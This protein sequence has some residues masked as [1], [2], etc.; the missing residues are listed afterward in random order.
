VSGLMEILE[1]LNSTPEGVHVG[2]IP[3]VLLPFALLSTI[4]SVVATFIANLF[5]VKLRAEG[6]KKLLEILLKPR[7]LISAFILNG[8]LYGGMQA[9][10]YLRNGP[11]PEFYQNLK[12]KNILQGVQADQSD[13]SLHWK[14][15]IVDDGF[16]ADAIVVDNELFAGSKKGHLYV[17]N[18]KTGL[19]THKVYIGKFIAPR[20]TFFKG[21]IYF[22]EGL[23]QSHHMQIY[24]LDIKTK[25]IVGRFKTKG[26]TEAMVVAA[27]IE[28]RDYLFF[29]AG[30]DGIYAI[31]PDSM[32]KIW[33]YSKGHMDSHPYIHKGH[34]YIGTG[35]PLQDLKSSRALAIKL[36]VK[37]GQEQWV[38]EIP[39][40]S[41]FG[42]IV[43]GDSICFPLGEIHVKSNLGGNQCF[44][45]SGE[46]KES[47]FVDNP[48]MGKQEANNETILFN[49]FK[50]TIYLWN[51][52]KGV[53]EWKIQNSSKRYSFSTSQK[54]EGSNYVFINR[55]GKGI[56]FDIRK[57]TVFKN[58]QFNKDESV[59]SD[60]IPYK[61]GVIVLGLGGTIKNYKK[62]GIVQ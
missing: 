47:L 49:D 33:H 34:L 45:F 21:H 19:L 48:V 52:H 36:D 31:D 20:L 55:D 30:N 3:T 44:S 38:R 4:I 42:P 16:F 18:L 32:K 2:I 9:Y 39:M 10:S 7:I 11:V 1:L 14:Q 51:L 24:K 46:R 54:V 25:K 43:V 15:S 28:G 62:K 57:G 59:F 12:N 61:D 37:N 8:F 22:G 41:W 56:F 5:G 35:V 26:H 29:A 60:P 58:F 53:V 13:P 23:H 6:P 27:T 50:G 17:F 40:S